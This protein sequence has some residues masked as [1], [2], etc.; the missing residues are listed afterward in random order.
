MDGLPTSRRVSTVRTALGPH[1][2]VRRTTS[3]PHAGYSLT[4]TSPQRPRNTQRFRL[5][6]VEASTL[7]H[8]TCQ[9]FVRQFNILDVRIFLNETPIARPNLLWITQFKVMDIRSLLLGSNHWPFAMPSVALLSFSSDL[10]VPLHHPILLKRTAPL[11]LTPFPPSH[12][13]LGLCWRFLFRF[14]PPSLRSVIWCQ[15]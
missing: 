6:G 9:Q 12:Y 11:R 5:I 7:L 4:P 1:K 3:D 8:E 2:L 15:N 13:D 14:L 10:H